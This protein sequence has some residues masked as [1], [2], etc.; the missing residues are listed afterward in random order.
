MFQACT[1]HFAT[2]VA[3]PDSGRWASGAEPAERLRAALL[4]FYDYYGR[5]SAAIC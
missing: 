4:T 5:A 3:W 1:A 2:E